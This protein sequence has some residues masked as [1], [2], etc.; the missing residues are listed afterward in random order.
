MP[1]RATPVQQI[2]LRTNY[3][4]AHMASAWIFQDPKQVAKRGA[5][6]ASW[7]VGWI[8]PQGKQRCKS[9]G[10]GE[11][12]KDKSD[13]ERIKLEDRLERGTYQ[14]DARRKWADFREEFTSR[15]ASGM[16]ASTRQLAE[17]ALDDFER[18][19]R[20][21]KMA[22]LKTQAIDDF[23]A[24]RRLERGRRPDDLISPATV[25]RQLRHLKAALRIAHEWG[26]LPAVPKMRML[27]EP[28]KLPRFVTAEHFAT[29]Y[30]ACAKTARW[31][32]GQN[33]TAA[34]W[35]RALLVT[36]YMTGW[37]IGSL[38]ALKR[39]DVN[40]E[41]GAAVSWAADNKGNRDQQVKLHPVV[42]EHLKK[43]P[44][45]S[46]FMFPWNHDERGLY[47]EF[48]RIQKAAGVHLPC[49]KKHEHA[50]GCH[51]YGFHDL[52][53]AFATVNAPKLTADALQ[54]L[55]QHKSYTTT[56]KYINMAKQIDDAVA[57]LHVP[58]V[59]RSGVA[60]G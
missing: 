55:M 11:K 7:Y 4:G 19:V 30:K 22:A 40:L 58:E 9:Y 2:Q 56:Q 43:L 38:L 31:P 52:R 21:K 35:W 34:D 59:L 57:V 45:F 16:P 32:D 27:K 51:V 29:M 6:A 28:G 17:E 26:Y 8:D 14:G 1:N 23:I 50:D 37:R 44:D 18:L 46:P 10:P 42:V 3:G 54:H 15:I 33:Y 13:Q 49:T 53:R 20:P 39:E 48:A 60:G 5:E 36:A 12:G 47:N 25:N 41:T 24:R